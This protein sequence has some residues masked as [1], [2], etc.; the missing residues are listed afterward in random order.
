MLP[1][2]FARAIGRSAI[3]LSCLTVCSVFADDPNGQIVLLQGEQASSK[4]RSAAGKTTKPTVANDAK[5]TANKAGDAAQRT[6]VVTP[7]ERAEREQRIDSLLKSVLKDAETLSPAIP[8]I[9]NETP[10]HLA[11][12]FAQLETTPHDTNVRTEFARELYQRDRHSAVI[13]VIQE[14]WNLGGTH[15]EW[16]FLFGRSL[17]LTGQSATASK[18]LFCATKE[19]PSSCDRRA[20][21]GFS[22]VDQRPLQTWRSL[23]CGNESAEGRAARLYVTGEAMEQLGLYEEA[24]ASYSAASQAC[25]STA[26]SLAADQSR[27]NMF[28]NLECAQRTS[29]SVTFT[30]FYDTNPGAIP[31]SAAFIN[32]FGTGK[33][34]GGNEYAANIAHDVYREGNDRLT[35]GGRFSHAA[36]YSAHNF[37]LTAPSLFADWSSKT[38]WRD[39][40]LT[41][42][43]RA[44]YGYV[45]FHQEDFLSDYRVRPY[46]ALQ[47]SDNDLLTTY[48]QFDV[49][50]FLDQGAADQTTF[51]Q[52]STRHAV[53]LNW[54]RV[55]L[56]GKWQTSAGYEVA[57]NN[58][59]GADFDYV[60]NAIVLGAAWAPNARWTISAN[61]RI[62]FRDYLNNN[63]VFRF[64]RYD[65]QFVNNLRVTRHLTDDLDL[66]VDYTHDRNDSNILISDFE[67][68]RLQLGV[69][70]AF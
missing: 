13:T 25:G 56:D 40:P 12:R 58:S 4:K 65:E 66:F 10:S 54:R 11:E 51:D 60:S 32:A 29:G 67:R 59:Q 14:G 7:A 57:F 35:V 28:R 36:N 8:P 18:Y 70:W 69:T 49:I 68:R 52:D 21:N 17:L 39:N 23:C 1:R 5:P 15:H 48:Y 62:G 37:D 26:W 61:S 20:W 30:Q 34:T 6:K 27:Q 19:C 41:Y 44:E 22:T 55:S 47:T 45:A 53:G 43:V 9:S 16:N 2:L 3:A 64:A 63:F 24:N 42:G 50:D 46:A 33:A 38:L 31:D